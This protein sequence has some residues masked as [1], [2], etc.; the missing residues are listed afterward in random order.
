MYLVALTDKSVRVSAVFRVRL[1]L[2]IYR[3]YGPSFPV[4]PDDKEL[5]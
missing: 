5:Q 4:L 1:N 2:G 3:L